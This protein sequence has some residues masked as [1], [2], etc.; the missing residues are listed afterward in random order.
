MPYTPAAGHRIRVTERNADG[1]VTR[2][3]TGTVEDTTPTPRSTHTEYVVRLRS[4]TDGR[5]Y[6][7]GDDASAP[8]VVTGT[9]QVTEQLP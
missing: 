9:S 1:R 5:P 6:P 2:I 7:I 4:D 8:L 3:L